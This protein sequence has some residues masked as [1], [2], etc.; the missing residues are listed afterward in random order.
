LRECLVSDAAAAQEMLDFAK[1]R[2]HTFTHV[3]TTD[4]LND[5]FEAAAAGLG[6]VLSGHAYGGGEVGAPL[7][8]MT[9]PCCCLLPLQLLAATTACCVLS[10]AHVACTQ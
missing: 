1:K 3:G 4:R 6:L 2:L 8:C 10:S 9:S 7:L 5:S